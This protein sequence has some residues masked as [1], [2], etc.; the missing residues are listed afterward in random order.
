LATGSSINSRYPGP[1]AVT[2]AD[3][4]AGNHFGTWQTCFYLASLDDDITLVHALDGARDDGFP[5]IEEI[6]QH[7]LAL[8]IANA[9]QDGL[10]GRLRANAA[11]LGRLN[12]VFDVFVDFN[13]RDDLLGIG[14]QLLAVGLLQA[15]FIGHHQ[16]TAI[17]FVLT[18]RAVD[19]DTNVGVFSKTPFDSRRQGV[20]KRLEY[21]VALDIFFTRQGTH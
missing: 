17:A 18:G 13:A 10:L 12:G 16:P 3:V 5:A 15:G 2:N 19:G 14:I 6:I 11:K 4:F 9:L 7:L 8:G 1:H 21:S 20:L